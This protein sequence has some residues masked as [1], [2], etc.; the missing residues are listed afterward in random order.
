[1]SDFKEVVKYTNIQIGDCLVEWA[2]LR[3]LNEARSKLFSEGLIGKLP[4]QPAHGNI[5]MLLPCSIRNDLLGS[6]KTEL[7]KHLDLEQQGLFNNTFIIT[8]TGTGGLETLTKTDFVVVLHYDPKT[9]TAYVVG[10]KGSSSEVP[11]HASVYKHAKELQPNERITSV[12]HGHNEMIWSRYLDLKLPSTSEKIPY[13]DPRMDE[14]IGI[15]PSYHQRI[16]KKRAFVMLGHENGVVSFAE[17]P[18]TA[19]E[20]LINLK[21]LKIKK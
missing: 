11:T 3:D 9:N 20:I 19:A 12:A 5:S 6:Y 1:M 7:R 14:Q 4:D 13:G 16:F 21:Q 10:E 15:L 8:A 17:N 18:K 2:T